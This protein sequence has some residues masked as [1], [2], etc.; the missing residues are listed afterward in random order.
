MQDS[1][2]INLIWQFH[3]PPR[4]FTIVYSP[5]VFKKLWYEK[6]WILVPKIVLSETTIFSNL[7]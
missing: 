4:S 1:C 2:N 7:S 3:S 6:L 5:P